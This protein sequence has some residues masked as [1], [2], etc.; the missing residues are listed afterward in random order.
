MKKMYR[1]IKKIIGIVGLCFLALSVNAQDF[2]Q[3]TQYINMQGLINPGYTGSRGVYSGLMNYR[4]QWAGFDASPRTLGFNFHGPVPVENLSAGLVVMSES[5]GL[6]SNVDLSLASAYAI[7][8]TRDIKLS[9]GVQ[10]GF[11]SL[12][13][14]AASLNLNDPRDP[15]YQSYANSYFRP[16]VGFG[17]FLYT[18]KYFAGFSMP[19]MLTHGAEDNSESIRT[20][21]DFRTMHM[22]L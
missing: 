1:T 6:N 5:L 7:N 3:Y 22:F 10:M 2:Q 15:L 18:E 12:Q 20:T 9:L 8:V 17:A 21:F 16:N 14:D 11:S 13:F 19:R 4:H